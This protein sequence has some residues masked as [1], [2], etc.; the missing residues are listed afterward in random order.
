MASVFS[1]GYQYLHPLLQKRHQIKIT[2]FA[3]ADL[4]IAAAFTFAVPTGSNVSRGGDK[5]PRFDFIV[6]DLSINGRGFFFKRV[7]RCIVG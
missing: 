7:Y 4:I 3:A 1:I 6:S 5:R 2:K